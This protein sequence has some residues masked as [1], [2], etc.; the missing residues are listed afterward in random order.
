MSRPNRHNRVVQMKQE[1]CQQEE[2]IQRKKREILE[3]QQQQKLVQGEEA[4]SSGTLFK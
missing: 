1:M 4:G 3:K 2:I